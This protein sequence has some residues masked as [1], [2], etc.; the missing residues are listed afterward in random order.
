[1]SFHAIILFQE[2]IQSCGQRFI[3]KSIYCIVVSNIENKKA[4]FSN[5]RIKLWQKRVHCISYYSFTNIT[6]WHLMS[7]GNAIV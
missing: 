2:S 4:D 3:C 6:L 7:Q 5:N 1:M